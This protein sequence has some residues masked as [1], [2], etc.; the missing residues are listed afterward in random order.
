[1][2]KRGRP[3]KYTKVLAVA[4]CEAVGKSPYGLETVCAEHPEFPNPLTIYRWE[5]K[6]PEFCKSFARARERRGQLLFDECLE[7]ADD[8]SNDLMT[9]KRGDREYEVENKEVTNRSRLR[10]E[11]RLKMA[12]KLAPKSL[13]DKIIHSN[14]PNSPLGVVM[15]PTQLPAGAEIKDYKAKK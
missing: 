7:I 6:Y 2:A 10:V 5:D 12:A 14:D 3:S 8:G 9:I 15:V 4:I 11:T 13:G 1:M